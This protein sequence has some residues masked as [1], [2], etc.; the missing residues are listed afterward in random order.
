MWRFHPHL[1]VESPS[2]VVTLG[3]GDTPLVE[4]PTLSERCG[5]RV[6]AKCEHLNPTGSYK[7]RVASVAAS[8][9]VER[10]MPGA[11]GTSSGNGGAALAAYC[12]AAH[13][14]ALLFTR[15]GVPAAKL[16]QMQAYGAEV[17]HVRRTAS[18]A[19]SVLNDLFATVQTATRR[20]GWLA[21]VT[22]F[23]INPE[24]MRG[25]GTI[26]YEIAEHDVSPAAIYVPIGGGG[27]LSGLHQGFAAI[28]ENPRLIAVQPAGNPTIRAALTGEPAPGR[29]T[30]ISGLQIETLVDADTAIPAV[31][32]SGG[33]TVE[34]TDEQI[35]A[36]QRLLAREEG[37]L[38]EPAG[39]ASVA[40][41]LTDVN[42]KQ[43]PP[44]GTIVVMLTGAGWKDLAA[45]DRVAMTGSQEQSAATIDAS[46]VVGLLS[47]LVH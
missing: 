5:T 37:I 14:K 6:L 7:D 20:S 41:L 34:V 12:A 9:L 32:T 10:N 39:A 30:T 27:L 28:G 8:L 36:A 38:V 29:G 42:R 33:H 31:T 18:D 1:P 43:A 24:A 21:F 3:E 17:Y 19:A 40:G 16:A 11:A 23:R 26:A 22:A 45:L 13:R 47:R 46:E 2:S 35:W 44:E 25:V 4:L 15:Q